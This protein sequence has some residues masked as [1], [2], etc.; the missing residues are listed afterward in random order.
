MENQLTPRQSEIYQYLRERILNDF[1]SPTVR[2]IGDHFGIKSP[3]GV[4]CH[5]KALEKKGLI[6]RSPLIPCGIRLADQGK[7]PVVEWAENVEPGA[8]TVINDAG[9]AVGV[10]R[11]VG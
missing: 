4:V 3:N 2:Q 6:E 9:T 11:R 8:Y 10:I 7:P 1:R 5:L